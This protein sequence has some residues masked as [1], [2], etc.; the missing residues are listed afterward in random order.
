[1]RPTLQT[2]QKEADQRGRILVYAAFPAKSGKVVLFPEIFIV[3]L[4]YD[5]WW[6][7]IPGA[8]A[9]PRLARVIS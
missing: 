8:C 1:M 4:V 2:G 3:L 7:R 6:S 9:V 5:R